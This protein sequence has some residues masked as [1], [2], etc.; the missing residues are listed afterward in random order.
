MVL[1]LGLWACG[2]SEKDDEEAAQSFMDV[3]VVTGLRLYDPNGA[4]IGLWRDPND[5]P[6]EVTF[7]PNP[8]GD[9]VGMFSQGPA[10]VRL[11]IVAA[12]CLHDTETADIEGQSGSLAFAVSDVSG[13][14]VRELGS[15]DPATALSIDASELAPG[16]YRLFV[17]MEAGG[18][19]WQNM[20]IDPSKG[21]FPDFGFL[22]GLCE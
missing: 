21:S 20:Y 7:Y 17:E 15:G 8:A 5:K 2:D 11:W 19:Y 13:I 22:D 16:L 3:D 10:V 14:A 4:A 6:G 1:V 18:V 9:F 12:D